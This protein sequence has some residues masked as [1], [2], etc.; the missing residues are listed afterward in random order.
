MKKFAAAVAAALVL[1]LLW[2]PSAQAQQMTVGSWSGTW[3]PVGQ[4]PAG[5]RHAPKDPQQIS[6]A[7]RLAVNN[8]QGQVVIGNSQYA[9]EMLSVYD[10]DTDGQPEYFTFA[11]QPREDYW[12]SCTLTNRGDE[13]FSG[14]CWDMNSSE[15]WMEMWRGGARAPTPG[16]GRPTG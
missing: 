10:Q 12:L 4:L 13:R 11:W 5:Q 7:V 15:G 3:T 8:P 2:T 1:T 9:M 6:F 14:L 16:E